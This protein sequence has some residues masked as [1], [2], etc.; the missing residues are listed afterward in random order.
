MTPN[1]EEAYRESLRDFVK[2]AGLNWG[3][4]RDE[5]K[6]STN[7]PV[8]EQAYFDGYMAAL[9]GLEAALDCFLE[10]QS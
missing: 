1:L 2:W 6:E 5:W 7:D 3:M 4:T 9:E 8:P 10:E